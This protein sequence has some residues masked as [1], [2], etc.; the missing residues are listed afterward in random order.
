MHPYTCAHVRA[1]EI[2]D[3]MHVHT[4]CDRA[5]AQKYRVISYY[6]SL[7][8]LHL[9]CYMA[10]RSQHSRPHTQVKNN[11]NMPNPTTKALSILRN[12]S[13]T[14]TVPDH[15]LSTMKTVKIRKDLRPVTIM[16]MAPVSSPSWQ[17]E[18]CFTCLRSTAS[19]LVK[20]AYKL[21]A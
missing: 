3:C 18:S 12:C 21:L 4:S 8:A 7:L 13:A 14:N 2:I 5:H 16:S 11:N 20:E 6:S 19:N 1:H 17:K 10:R 15:D 9:F